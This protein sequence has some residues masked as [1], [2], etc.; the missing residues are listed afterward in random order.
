MRYVKKK[1]KRLA[2][3]LN[4]VYVLI[5]KLIILLQ[6]KYIAQCM[7]EIKQELRQEN[8]AV[9]ATAV[10]KLTYVTVLNEIK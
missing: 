9:K 3:S 6:A 8:V 10:A 5:F 7:E 1:S 4:C 2:I